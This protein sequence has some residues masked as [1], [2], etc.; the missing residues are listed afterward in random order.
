MHISAVVVTHNRKEWLIDCVNAIRGQSKHLDNI[1][2]VDNDSQDGTKA[3]LLNQKDLDVIYQKNVG[4]AGGFESGIKKAYDLGSEWIWCLDD[5]VEP[6]KNALEEMLSFSNIS[7]CINTNKITH[8]GELIELG[9]FMDLL[10]SNKSSGR[11]NKDFGKGWRE[12]E[13]ACF[14]G[15][16]IHKDIVSKIGYP[17]K[18]MFIGGD[19]TLYGIIASI[20]TKVILLEKPVLYKKKLPLIKNNFFLKKITVHSSNY[21][22]FVI[23]NSFILKNLLVTCFGRSNICMS[24]KIMLYSIKCILRP[25]FIKDISINQ[26]FLVIKALKDGFKISRKYNK[27]FFIKYNEKAKVNL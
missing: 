16:L 9:G 4:G 21:L 25:V 17:L 23:R 26:S 3:W 15:M 6:F 5:D 11:V 8:N 18:E 7:S 13:G 12:F 27:D 22:Y 19:D 10:G 2:V 1:I 14:E 24:F 20:Y